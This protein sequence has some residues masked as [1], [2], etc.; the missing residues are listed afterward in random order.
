ME[1]IV[2]PGD[3]QIL[4]CFEAE[5]AMESL[6][7]ERLRESPSRIDARERFQTGLRRRFLVSTI[8]SAIDM[9]RSLY[10]FQEYDVVG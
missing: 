5:F 1:M 3:E 6:P 2:L 8:K 10:S 4:E 9:S 7:I